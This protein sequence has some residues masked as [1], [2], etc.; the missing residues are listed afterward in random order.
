MRYAA[1]WRRFAP[2]TLPGHTGSP[3]P[4]PQEGRRFGVQC[5]DQNSDFGGK[6]AP[7]PRNWRMRLLSTAAP[8]PAPARWYGARV[9]PFRN[10]AAA[11]VLLATTAF[12]GCG[13]STTKTV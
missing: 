4:H 10:G 3:A 11:L 12:A 7:P 9:T 13:E 6:V 8:E 2:V 5:R 1:D